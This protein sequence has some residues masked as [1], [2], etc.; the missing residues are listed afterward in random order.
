MPVL[1]GAD[2]YR[3]R[4]KRTIDLAWIEAGDSPFEFF[5]LV[6]L[7]ASTSYDFQYRKKNWDGSFPTDWSSSGT[8]STEVIISS[9]ATLARMPTEYVDTR[10]IPPTAQTFNVTTTAE[11]QTALNT[12]AANGGNAVINVALGT[13]DGAITYPD[14]PGGWIYIRSTSHAALPALTELYGDWVTPA[15]AA[16]MPFF[17]GTVVNTGVFTAAG[18]NCQKYRFVG[19][20]FESTAAT[21]YIL[22]LIH[23]TSPETDDMPDYIHFDRCIFDGS[24]NGTVVRAILAAGRG[25]AAVGCYFYRIA[26]NQDAQAVALLAS[27]GLYKFKG[28]YTSATGENWIAGGSTFAGSSYTHQ[29]V[30]MEFGENYFYHDPAWINTN[31]TFNIKNS[32]ELKTGE[33]VLMYRNRF[34]NLWPDGQAGRAVVFTPRPF[35]DSG[36]DAKIYDLSFYHN[37]IIDVSQGISAASVDSPGSSDRR[38]QRYSFRYNRM[39]TTGFGGWDFGSGAPYPNQT[40]ICFL[41]GQGLDDCLIDHFTA[42]PTYGGSGTIEFT[43]DG[44]TDQKINRFTILNSVIP[45]GEYGALRNSVANGDAVLNNTCV[46]RVVEKNAFAGAPSGTYPTNNLYPADFAAMLF[47]NL[48][49]RNYRLTA[50]SPGKGYATDGGD[51]GVDH[52]RLLS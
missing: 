10:Y 7:T 16:L 49:L 12:A 9:R 51:I 34:E 36:A 37:D 42:I 44:T 19:V 1:T 47:E 22:G 35:S 45:S 11:F 39:W 14:N 5:H 31:P 25:H 32:F 18:V 23:P 43:F 6:G 40:S 50:S 2:F 33:R 20:R 26:H 27:R 17:R 48:A 4:Y 3:V 38:G 8:G 15:H 13:Y 28:N 52:S 24:N 29:P 21:S 41:I 30:D 46:S